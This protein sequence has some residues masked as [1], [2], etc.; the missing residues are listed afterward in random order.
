M[1]DIWKILIKFLISV[2]LVSIAIT[3]LADGATLGAI[4]V[5]ASAI[6]VISNRSK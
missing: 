2:I 4:L 1:K 6:F 3:L 5:F